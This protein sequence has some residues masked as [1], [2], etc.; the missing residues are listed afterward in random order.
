[1]Q[2]AKGCTWCKYKH[3][4]HKDSNDGNGLRTFRYSTGYKYLTEV[5]VEPKVDEIL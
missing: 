4:C 2:L 1:M 3:E 5:V